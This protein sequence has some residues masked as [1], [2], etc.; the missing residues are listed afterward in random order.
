MPLRIASLVVVGATAAAFAAE[1]D[2]NVKT[3][4]KK[5]RTSAATVARQA[6]TPVAERPRPAYDA[7]GQRYGDVI[8]FPSIMASA[9]YDDNIFA[10]RAIR[11][12]DTIF[13]LTPLARV[14]VDLGQTKFAGYAKA[15][16]RRFVNL[17]QLNSVAPEAGFGGKVEITRD[18][19]VQSRVDYGY[20]V[21]DPGVTNAFTNSKALGGLVRY[22]DITTNSGVT[23]N[24]GRIFTSLS[25]IGQRQIYN[26]TTD[27]TGALLPMSSRYNDKATVQWRLGYEFGPG[28]RAFVMP[29]YDARRNPNAHRLDANG[30]SVSGGLAMDMTR[31]LAGEVTV[32]YMERN[33]YNNFF[34]KV[35]GMAV[36]ARLSWFP[37]DLVT[38]TTNID[39]DLNASTSP[40]ASNPNGSVFYTTSGS[41]KVDYEVLRNFILSTRSAVTDY[42]YIRDTRHTREYSIGSTATYLFSRYLQA[43]LD[44]KRTLSYTTVANSDYTRNVF[45]LSVKGQF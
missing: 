20:R 3:T 22:H 44:Y 24:F 4:R 5:S 36:G 23:A 32:G 14:E 1:D 13:K 33:Y 7:L 29:T 35:G 18:L 31:L 21:E 10:Q 15:E 37:T 28:L 19:S 40:S 17:E 9:A 11:A 2:V 27:A 25:T 38:V 39:R 12:R 30:Y 16:I 43:S 42:S 34:G 26:D 45:T 41:V 8:F 6:P